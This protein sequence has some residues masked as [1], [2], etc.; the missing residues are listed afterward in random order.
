MAMVGTQLATGTGSALD[1]VSPEFFPGAGYGS[2]NGFFELSNVS[3]IDQR[4][5]GLAA[6]TIEFYVNLLNSSVS[7]GAGQAIYFFAAAPG[8]PMPS[9]IAAVQI[10]VSGANGACSNNCL[11]F[12]VDI[13]G[14]NV[15]DGHGGRSNIAAGNMSLG[16]THHIALSYDGT[17]IRLF[18]DGTIVDSATASGTWTVPAYESWMLDNQFFQCYPGTCGNGLNANPAYYDSLRISNTARYTS[19]FTAPTAKFASDGNTLF[20]MNFPTNAPTG[21]IQASQGGSTVY[22]PIETSNGAALLNPAYIGNL[23]LSGNGIFATWMINSTIENIGLYAGVGGDHQTCVNL[24]N[25]DF[26]DTVRRVF[27]SAGYNDGETRVGFIF[28]N[29][30]NNNVYDHLQCD[31]QRSCIGELGGSGH[32]IMPDY[33]DRGDVIYPLYFVQAQAILDSPELDVEDTA[34]N[35]LATVYS[36]GEYAPTIING[37]QLCFGNSNSGTAYLAIQ[38]GAPFIV[39]GTDF[40]CNQ[41]PAELLNVLSNPSSPVTIKDATLPNVPLTNAGAQ[42]WLVVNQFGAVYNPGPSIISPSYT[43]GAYDRYLDCNATSAPVALNLP[44]ATGNGRLISFKK[45]D[46]STNAC[47]ITCGGSDKIDGVATDALASQYAGL[48]LRDSAAG[49]WDIVK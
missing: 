24:A 11:G 48:T 45:T 25:N 6:F 36:S 35:N 38:G 19:N 2:N 12:S 9:N 42:Q 46:S 15:N 20:L 22:I 5:N 47:T 13:G 10:Y 29:Q 31:G 1:T 41:T 3:H 27:C 43:V 17:T 23:T 26:Q 4:A 32:Y 39:N 18:K 33:T 14:L 28:G 40:A 8:Q 30:G 49:M 34:S 21:T 16:V 7:F 44:A 37:G